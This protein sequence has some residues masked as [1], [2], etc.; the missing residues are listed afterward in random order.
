M[1]ELSDFQLV[2]VAKMYFE[3][4][5]AQKEIAT[6]LG[7]S[8][9]TV[10][11]MLQ[12]ARETEVVQISIKLPFQLVAK[13]SDGLL[14]AYPLDRAFVLKGES[15][16]VDDLRER[17]GGVAA[18]LLTMEKLDK[19][20][21]GMG[22]GATIGQVVQHLLP[23]K[24]RD[25][26]IVQLM[27]GLSDVSDANPFT[28]VQETCRR[29]NAKGTY[30]TANAVVE[31]EEYRRHLLFDTPMGSETETLWK[32]C[33][34]AVFGVGSIESG[35]LLSETLVGPA[36]LE[37]VRKQGAVGDIL[38]HCLDKEGRFV[39]TDLEDRLVSIPIASLKQIGERTAVAGGAH[40]VGAIRAALRSGMVTTLITDEKTASLLV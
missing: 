12:K 35:T 11:R 38:G 19:Q 7:L 29:L 20:V 4:G 5:M 3:N 40:K 32:R 34:K 33:T 10:S 26:H 23:M 15:S 22:V 18:F 8:K 2:Q 39:Q 1:I 31:N 24:T 13:L 25:L 36:E 27:G 30:L 9:M 6:Y 21:L 17:I 14:K 37:R 16:K 28:I